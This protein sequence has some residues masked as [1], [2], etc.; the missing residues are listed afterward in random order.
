[1]P[2][3]KGNIVLKRVYDRAAQ[4]DGYR[5]LVDRLWP[6]GITKERAALDEWM[7]EIAPSEAL[8]RMFHGGSIN[9]SEFKEKYMDEL[10]SGD[11][12]QFLVGELRK[13]AERGKVTLL[14]GSKNPT[15][16]HALILLQY[17]NGSE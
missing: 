17:I 7:K 10:S 14:Y 13:L 1:M 4:S 5:I 12:Q 3:V 9:F 16:N 6:R 2:E 15:D 8:R 11:K